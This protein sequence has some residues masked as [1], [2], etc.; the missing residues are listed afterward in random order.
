[1][2]TKQFCL[3]IVIVVAGAMA[4]MAAIAVHK[5]ETIAITEEE[6]PQT[7]YDVLAVPTETTGV[8]CFML[9]R[10]NNTVAQMSC[11]ELTGEEHVDGDSRP[12]PANRVHGLSNFYGQ[13]QALQ[14]NEW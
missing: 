6:Q 14:G 11:I 10:D 13:R 5:Y 3:L 8:T 12:Y 9:L 2:K 1:M 7:S 4:A